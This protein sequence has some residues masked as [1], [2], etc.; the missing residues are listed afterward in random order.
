MKFDVTNRLKLWTYLI[1]VGY[2]VA[3][4]SPA[5]RILVTMW[6]SFIFFM[7]I[8]YI[9]NL[10]AF[11][12]ARQPGPPVVPFKTWGEMT[13][14]SSVSYGLKNGGIMHRRMQDSDNPLLMN[15]MQN[16]QTFGTFYTSD[17][18]GVDKVRKSDGN[19]A[20]IVP[21]NIGNKYVNSEPCDLMLVGE[22]IERSSYGIACKSASVCD[23]LSQ[24]ILSCLENGEIHLLQLK[25]FSSNN[26]C[27]S[28][29]LMNYISKHETARL[30]AAPL[31]IADAS[32]AF[33]VLLIG[34]VLCIIFLIVE[35]VVS[36]RRKP[37]CIMHNIFFLFQENCI[38][39]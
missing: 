34:V 26:K 7:V 12:L 20:A 5:G 13:S 2:K 21:T 18:A 1:I 3:P 4:R 30:T 28:N 23:S 16:I 6:F 38:I 24:A 9:S 39:P 19:F 25:W 27:P 15:A 36:R 22:T 37:V 10:T 17:Q 29:N 8:A 32:L 35:L 31:T 33:V 14:Q 11:L